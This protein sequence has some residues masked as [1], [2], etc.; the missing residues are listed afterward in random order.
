MRTLG[1]SMI[2]PVFSYFAMH[3]AWATELSVGLAIGIFGF[4]QAL[5]QIP[6]G[7]LIDRFGM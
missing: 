4:S 7:L 6:M 3:L 5:F 2:T 1:I